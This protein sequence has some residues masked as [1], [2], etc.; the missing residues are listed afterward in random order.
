[1]TLPVRKNVNWVGEEKENR[2]YLEGKDTV[3]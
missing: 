3:R 1:M 2:T